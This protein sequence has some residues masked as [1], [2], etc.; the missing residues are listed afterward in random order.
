M[1][2]SNPW[3]ETAHTNNRLKKD[4]ALKNIF[5][6][7]PYR[8]KNEDLYKTTAGLLNVFHVLSATVG[9][10]GLVMV[11][12]F[13]F[14]YDL[15]MSTLFNNPPLKQIIITALLFGGAIFLLAKMEQIKG[16]ALKSYQRDK[17]ALAEKA[18]TSGRNL[19]MLL[20][21]VNV[22]LSLI[23]AVVLVNTVLGT[24]GIEA[25]AAVEAEHAPIIAALETEYAELSGD[26]YKNRQGIIFYNHQPVVKAKMSELTAA[27]A[28]YTTAKS[29]V[30]AEY[31]TTAAAATNQTA[32]D[33]NLMITAGMM[34]VQF[35]IEFML[36][37]LIKWR[38]NY[39]YKSYEEMMMEKSGL[40]NN[41]AAA[42]HSAPPVV[43]LTKDIEAGEAHHITGFTNK[44]EIP[45]VQGIKV[46]TKHGFVTMPPSKVKQRIL[47]CVKAK[48]YEQASELSH[49]L[50][51]FQKT[52]N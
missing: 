36:F 19:G 52:T 16:K 25:M 51:L 7:R 24:K 23:G 29:E 17:L 6:A 12:S 10:F 4:D 33:K 34:G 45:K 28:A 42:D 26:G 2:L 1:N 43:D 47:E 50:T 44:K 35:F 11:L 8:E 37:F 21:G 48:N 30:K 46:A 9:I 27:R 18:D 41:T 32:S 40:I 31:G 14:G 39:E 3:A 13:L 5:K 38:C 20:S 22:V 49:K 15:N